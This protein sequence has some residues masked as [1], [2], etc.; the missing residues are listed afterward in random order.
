MI[1]EIPNESHSNRNSP[2]K[3]YGFDIEL[4]EEIIPEVRAFPHRVSLAN[5]QE[6]ATDLNARGVRRT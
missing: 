4:F 5:S 6:A 2:V 3:E 1:N